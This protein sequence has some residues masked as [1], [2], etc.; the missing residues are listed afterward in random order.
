MTRFQPSQP[1]DIHTKP[2]TGAIAE[3]SDNDNRFFPAITSYISKIDG[4][5]VGS[6]PDD[7]TPR[8]K[9]WFEDSILKGK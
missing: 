6:K 9:L 8:V 4:F 5:Q 7:I 2:N 3:I 1:I